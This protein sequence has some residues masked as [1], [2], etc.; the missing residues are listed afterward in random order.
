[1]KKLFIIA[2]SFFMFACSEEE[3]DS[4][5]PTPTLT[6][7][8]VSTITDTAVTFSGII[9]AP[10][11]DP[12]V[13]SQGFV[14]SLNTLPKITDEFI[15]VNGKAISKEI[16]GLQQNRT[17]Y[18]RTYFTNPTGT[19]YGNEIMFK[20]QVGVAS[21]NPTNISNIAAFS[22]EVL[23]SIT[24]NGGGEISLRGVCWNTTGSPTTSDS[25]TE[26]GS[27][28]GSF[29]NL[30][31]KLTKG[32]KY[33]LRTYAV[34][35]GGT[36]YSEEGS[37]TTR[38]GI[39]N[40]TT[41]QISNIRVSSATIAGN[42]TDDGGAEI[43]ARGFCWSTNPTPTIA[44]SKTEE[45]S[46]LGSFGSSLTGLTEDTTYNLRSYATNEAGTTYG[47]QVAF[48]TK[49]G[50]VLFATTSISNIR[51]S[52]ATIAGNITDDGGAEI[53]ARG[54][55]WSTNPTPTI[56]DSK[57]E[58]GSGLGSFG[59]SLTG[60][61]EDTTYNLRSYAT[62]EAGTTYGEQVAFTTKDGIVLFATTSI[63]N[64]RVSSATIAGNIT[65]DGGAEITARGFCWS[66][67]P[68]PTIADSKTE[69]GSGLGSF[70]SSLTGLTEDSIYYVRAY[71]TNE[72][73]TTYGE[74]ISFKTYENL[75]Y[76]DENSITVKAKYNAKIGSMGMV[77]GVEYTVVDS[78][79]L[80]QMIG[81][82][83]DVT[84]VCT[85]RITDMNDMFYSAQN[86]NQD[87]SAWDVSNVTTMSYMFYNAQNFN[88]NLSTWDVSNVTDMEYM[89]YY[90]QNFNQDLSTWDVSN[91]TDMEYMFFYAQNFNQ[92][93]STWDVSNV[94]DMEYMFWYAQN[95]NQDLS[96]WDVSNVTN[97]SY[98][99]GIAQNFNQDLSAWDV[100]NVTNM[101]AM[102]YYAA[103]FS[104]DLSAWDVSNVTNM[105]W[106]FSSA[107]NFNQDLS[108]WDVSNVTDMEYMF[109]NAQN[110]NQ[111]LSTWDVSNVTTMRAMFFSAFNFNQDLS[112][113][114]VSNVLYVERFATT[115]PQWTLP[116]PNFN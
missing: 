62:N 93:L 15:E 89:F 74:E 18:Y 49:D 106:M 100:S 109:Y 75:V 30:L 56:A 101:G 90:A 39:I 102:F 4:C 67:N 114:D 61:T 58:E 111:D 95:F 78:N 12:T 116:K 54:F 19:Y 45:G 31:T 64:I 108:T 107:W 88:Q 80:I 48:T 91:V 11:C 51:V 7:N 66:T 72:I 105:E 59:S 60:L 37:F 57:T 29:T 97:M 115:T 63:S 69:E 43:T 27:G 26:N 33:Y 81:S 70:G 2:L 47:E 77:N 79:T 104:Q 41:N 36:T 24:T 25:K 44:D 22:A 96:T 16:T 71:A 98:M 53:T 34:N 8:E 52:S 110:F 42:I 65:D 73:R 9:E 50:I 55:C 10:T 28:M 84:T 21:S 14:Y 94:T 3:E 83:E 17:Y 32:T 23:S 13:T 85:T 38:D 87:L 112:T 46:G 6:T 86:F 103:Y 1:M 20:T 35:Q 99:F 82:G 68:T 40:L 92:D 5:T 113:W 76:L